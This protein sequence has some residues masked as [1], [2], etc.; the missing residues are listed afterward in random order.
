MFYKTDLENYIEGA[1]TLD[2]C[3]AAFERMCQHRSSVVDDFLF[4]ESGNYNFSGKNEF[5]LSLVRQYK[6]NVF[7]DRDTQTRLDLVFPEQKIGFRNRKLFKISISSDQKGGSFRGFFHALRDNAL[8]AYLKEN[9]VPLL[10][11]EI[12][13]EEV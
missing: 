2:D 1:Q 12:E 6:D 5:Y 7:S 9:N 4:A 3:I 10:R 13:E 8:L 11:Y